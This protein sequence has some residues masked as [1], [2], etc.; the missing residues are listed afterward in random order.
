MKGRETIGGLCEWPTLAAI[1][2]CYAGGSCRRRHNKT[3]RHWHR[4]LLS[5]LPTQLRV[6]LPLQKWTMAGSSGTKDLNLEKR[7]CSPLQRDFYI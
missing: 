5:I 2:A 6:D 7:K 1:H 3:L 4:V